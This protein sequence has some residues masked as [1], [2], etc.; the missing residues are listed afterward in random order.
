MVLG[1]F[2]ALDRNGRA[3]LLLKL[4]GLLG[5]LGLAPWGWAAASIERT[6]LLAASGSNGV[7][8]LYLAALA[9][10]H[11]AVFVSPFIRHTSA[12]IGLTIVG[13]VGFGIDQIVQHATGAGI[14]IDLMQTLWQERTQASGAIQ[15]YATSISIALATVTGLFAVLVISPPRTFSLGLRYA[16]IPALALALA[17]ELMYVTR[18][19][20]VSE[21]PSPV[22]APALFIMSASSGVRYRGARDPVSYQNTIA[23]KFK[24]IVYIV[25]ESVRADYLELNSPRFNN[26]PFLSSVRDKIANFGVAISSTNCSRGARYTLRTGLRQDQLPDAKEVGLHQ[27]S[28]WQ[29]AKIAGYRTVHIDAFSSFDPF[30]SFMNAAEAKSID[31]TVEPKSVAYSMLDGRIA[32]ELVKLIEASDVP[33]FIFVEKFGVH[34]P[35][36]QAVPDT[37]QFDVAGLDKLPKPLS[38]VQ[39]AEVKT[40]L[41]AV[42]WSVDRFF[43]ATF[44]VLS[45]SDTLVIYTSDHG[46]SMYEGGYEATHCTKINP[47]PGEAM[48]PLIAFT[49]EPDFEARLVAEAGRSHDRASHFDIYPQVLAAMGYEAGWVKENFGSDL[50]SIPFDRKRRFSSTQPLK[51]KALWVNV[52]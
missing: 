7:L 20:V 39:S 31:L 10:A 30:H 18:E 15:T 51:S 28:V 46:Q 50:L 48:V 25:D 3:V 2:L 42:R 27:P 29:Y 22:G 41:R 52:D 23:P 34:S 40:Y 4:L 19:D 33:K 26:T 9:S 36:R 32:D 13:L 16:A 11:A 43:E 6:R 24:N 45:R 12:R 17:I 44:K 14:T 49:G 21:L 47:H 8:L 5:M 1:R 35:W 37:F 38:E